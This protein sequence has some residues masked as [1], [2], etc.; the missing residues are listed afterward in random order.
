MDL[1]LSHAPHQELRNHPFIAS[2][3]ATTPKEERLKQ[4]AGDVCRLTSFPFQISLSCS[5]TVFRAQSL[6]ARSGLASFHQTRRRPRHSPPQTSR[7][8]SP[9]FTWPTSRSRTETRSGPYT[10]RV[11]F[12][13]SASRQARQ[14]PDPQTRILTPLGPRPLGIGPCKEGGYSPLSLSL[15]VDQRVNSNSYETH[16]KDAYAPMNRRKVPPRDALTF[17]AVFFGEGSFSTGA[18]KSWQS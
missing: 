14:Y 18:N 11:S 4:T 6:S 8:I 16:Q 12:S 1:D 17:V 2:N 13:Q 7:S 10:R 3:C 5:L 15:S 9:T